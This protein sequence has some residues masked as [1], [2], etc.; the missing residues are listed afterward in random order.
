MKTFT[1]LVLL[2]LGCISTPASAA[3][4]TPPYVEINIQGIEEVAPLLNRLADAIDNL[5]ATAGLLPG[6]GTQANGP[7]PANST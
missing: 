4:S 6:R 5:S 7:L 1:P 2:W 3:Q